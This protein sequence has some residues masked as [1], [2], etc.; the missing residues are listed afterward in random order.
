[1]QR[2][3]P[4]AE[5]VRCQFPR[6]NRKLGRVDFLC[7][8]LA[9]RRLM[10]CAVRVAAPC[11]LAR[12]CV[13]RRSSRAQSTRKIMASAGSVE[14][15][16]NFGQASSRDS[17]VY[18]VV[19]PG[20][21]QA[22]GP[23]GPSVVDDWAAEMKAKG[24]SRVIS[25]L[26]DSE[27]GLYEK[28]LGELYSKH[29]KRC[30]PRS[31]R[32]H[33]SGVSTDKGISGN[34]RRRSDRPPGSQTVCAVRHRPSVAS[35]RSTHTSFPVSLTHQLPV[36]FCRHDLIN[37]I[38]DDTVGSAQTYAK[39][40][41]ALRDAEAAGENVVVHCRGGEGRTGNVFAAW[42]IARHGMSPEEAEKEVLSH[43]TAVGAT[44]RCKAAKL[45]PFA[46]SL[47]K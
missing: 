1:M 13:S 29:F 22:E 19:R 2:A 34:K 45:Q 24:V 39:I 32:L 5:R 30:A 36:G 33:E 12:L 31:G 40:V 27:L 41:E 11:Q 46:D 15:P 44:R 8:I 10:Q 4:T 9:L 14:Y 18:G 47:K 42:L 20:G 26:D 35:Q 6:F 17:I 25:L 21:S 38:P 23:F 43:A 37:N 28:P 16:L 7:H 3:W